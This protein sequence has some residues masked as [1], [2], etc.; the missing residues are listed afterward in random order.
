MMLDKFT[1]KAQAA[2]SDANETAFLRNHPEVNPWHLLH[3]LVEQQDGLVPPLFRHMG[4]EPGRV[5]Q[6]VS[7]QLDSMPR[8]VRVRSMAAVA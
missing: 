4:I 5:F 8:S 3:A 6:V 7:S 2:V 1:E